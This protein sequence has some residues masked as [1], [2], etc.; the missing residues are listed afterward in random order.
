MARGVF[1]LVYL[2]RV[3]L[4]CIL[5]YWVAFAISQ[6]PGFFDLQFSVSGFCCAGYLWILDLN[7]FSR[8]NGVKQEQ[9]KATRTRASYKN[10]QIRQHLTTWPQTRQARSRCATALEVL[11]PGRV[12]RAALA[13]PAA[14][15]APL[16]PGGVQPLRDRLVSGLAGRAGHSRS[17]KAIDYNSK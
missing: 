10:T 4:Y 7:V 14:D 8:K 2:L 16:P 1:G 17:R 5:G 15:A 13:H 9:Q 11:R 6:S 3:H 12:H